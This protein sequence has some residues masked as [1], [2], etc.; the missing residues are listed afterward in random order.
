MAKKSSEVHVVL[1]RMEHI[2]SVIGDAEK[3]LSP[4]GYRE[5]LESLI[6]EADGWKM[7]LADL[8]AEDE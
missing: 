1:K 2:R 3:G 4:A 5:L 8:G 7:L 6:S